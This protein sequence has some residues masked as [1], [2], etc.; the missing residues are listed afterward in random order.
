MD[1]EPAQQAYASPDASALDAD[2]FG[3]SYTPPMQ[4]H[5]VVEART[6]DRWRVL[7]CTTLDDLDSALDTARALRAD[8]SIDEVCLTLETTGTQGREARREI[9]RLGHD[10][11][12]ENYRVSTKR[13]APQV[14]HDRYTPQVSQ[15]EYAPPSEPNPALSALLPVIKA[16]DYDIDEEILEALKPRPAR[17]T[18]QSFEA[19]VV[20]QAQMPE[21]PE[22]A[23]SPEPRQT[24]DE[25]PSEEEARAAARALVQSLYGIGEN[26]AG[27]PGISAARETPQPT[28]AAEDVIDFNEI[29]PMSENAKRDAAREADR[30]EMNAPLPQDPDTNWIDDIETHAR[31]R[32]ESSGRIEASDDMTDAADRLE[33]PLIGDPSG[34]ATKAFIV[35][36][37]LAMMVLG[38]ALAELLAVDL[39]TSARAGHSADPLRS[40][41]PLSS[42]LTTD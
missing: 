27:Q 31:R 23:E 20:R 25:T 10:G 34:T 13:P 35:A 41:A 30:A 7:L 38:G 15:P 21:A 11:A 40:P 9:I 26:D 42:G 5:L 16:P 4:Q 1:R 32:F 19:D 3:A 37:T 14:N 18:P 39:T 17:K 29:A 12:P 24:A 8:N 28:P 22:P 36:G 2:G 6:D 33:R